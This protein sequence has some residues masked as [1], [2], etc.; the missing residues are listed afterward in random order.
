MPLPYDELNHIGQLLSKQGEEVCV[1]CVEY[2]R[3][4]ESDKDLWRERTET[5]IKKL[6]NETDLSVLVVETLDNSDFLGNELYFDLLNNYY[7]IL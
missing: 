3:M 1:S 7:I 5:Y 6:V 2:C 4:D